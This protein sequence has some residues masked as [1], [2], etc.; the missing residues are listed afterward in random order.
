VKNLEA[1]EFSL[2]LY[3]SSIRLPKRLHPMF[4]EFLHPEMQALYEIEHLIEGDGIIGIKINTKN[5]AEIG[6]KVRT[7]GIKVSHHRDDNLYLYLPN[8]RGLWYARPD[9]FRLKKVSAKVK[10]KMEG[11]WLEFYYEEARFPIIDSAF[12]A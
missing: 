10:C 3:G 5:P 11:D 2:T 12:K 7:S 6:K 1:K 8:N 9:M 4:H